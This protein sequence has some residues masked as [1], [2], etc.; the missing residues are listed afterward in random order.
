MLI[1]PQRPV[2]PPRTTHHSE[3]QLQLIRRYSKL[4]RESAS[5]ARTISTQPGQ[6]HASRRSS[7]A[8]SSAV[9][10]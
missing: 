1:Q 9:S 3:A 5:A 7:S 2:A 6:R 10:G 8:S 4:L